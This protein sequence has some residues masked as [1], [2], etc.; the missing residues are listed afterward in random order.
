MKICEPREDVW[1]ESLVFAR[2][3]RVSWDLW[4]VR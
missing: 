4:G 2:M 1:V 3:R